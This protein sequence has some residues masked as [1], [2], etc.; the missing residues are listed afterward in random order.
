MRDFQGTAPPQKLQL[1]VVKLLQPKGLALQWDIRQA[2]DRCA[3]LDSFHL[4]FF[5]DGASTPFAWTRMKVIKA[6][7]LP[8]F[9]T[10]GALPAAGVYYF[11]MQAKD[12]YGRYGPFSAV[13]SASVP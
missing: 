12:V 7:P 3:P 1:T 5:V 11:T 10:L 4:F 13:Q 8:M 6:L 2:G 9:I